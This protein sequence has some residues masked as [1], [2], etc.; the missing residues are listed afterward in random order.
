MTGPSRPAPPDTHPGRWRMLALIA[1]SVLLGMS[2]WFAGSAAAPELAARW[3][4][5]R[6]QVGWLATTVQLGFVAGTALS[7]LLNLA[8]VVPGRILFPA[9]A[10]LGA[11]ANAGLAVA[12]TFPAAL[13]TRF[14]AG[15]FIAGV[16]PPALKMAATWF[17][18]RRGPIG[19]DG[20]GKR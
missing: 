19:S 9:A 10:V 17:R 4:L 2:L 6:S 8:D 13:A 20:H 3:Q 18:A 1:T 15:F 14:G 11:L 7:A 12:P 16:Y 5:D